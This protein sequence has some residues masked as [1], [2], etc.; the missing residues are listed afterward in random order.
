MVP[1]TRQGLQEFHS[2]QPPLTEVSESQ[3]DSL[4][5]VSESL[6]RKCLI[7]YTSA[8]PGL[9]CPDSHP[10]AILFNLIILL[11]KLRAV[12]AP[13]LGLLSALVIY[14]RLVS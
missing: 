7:K 6:T 11:S 9:E 5:D 10:D 8:D 3:S 2:D 14:H 12:N 1:G 4:D 13:A